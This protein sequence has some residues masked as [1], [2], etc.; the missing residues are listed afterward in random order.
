MRVKKAAY[1]RPAQE[2]EDTELCIKQFH[3]QTK[4]NKWVNKGA[5]TGT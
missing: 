2:S 4:L 5:H 3:D 1:S